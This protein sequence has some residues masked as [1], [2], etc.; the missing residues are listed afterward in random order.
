MQRALSRQL[1]YMDDKEVQGLFLDV[2]THREIL[3]ASFLM[4]LLNILSNSDAPSAISERGRY[5]DEFMMDLSPKEQ[6]QV[7]STLPSSLRD[8]KFRSHL[9]RLIKGESI[10]AIVEPG[11]HGEGVNPSEPDNLLLSVHEKIARAE[12][13][14]TAIHMKFIED[15]HHALDMPAPD[16]YGA[17]EENRED[18]KEGQPDGGHRQKSARSII[19]KIRAEHVHQNLLDAARQVAQQAN[20]AEMEVMKLKRH[21]Q[22]MQDGAR[23]SEKASPS[24]AIATSDSAI[25]AQDLPVEDVVKNVPE[26]RT[27]TTSAFNQ[28]SQKRLPCLYK[29]QCQ[30]WSPYAI[31]CSTITLLLPHAVRYT[32]AQRSGWRCWVTTHGKTARLP[33][34]ASERTCCEAPS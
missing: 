21:I 2:T 24:A 26:A 17:N 28:E 18:G 1:S 33:S 32:A 15:M 3:D 16:V 14:N 4:K 19:E 25:A 30:R 31:L 23:R 10:N 8:G 29:T 6:K 22:Q 11:G 34:H 5:I 12:Y 27:T 20:E 9:K 7:A 13:S